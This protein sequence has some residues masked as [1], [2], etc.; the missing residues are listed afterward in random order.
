[1]QKLTSFA[2]LA[3]L[4]ASAT[5]Q[6]FESNYGTPLGTA[7]TLVGDIVLPI[8]SIGFAFPLAGTTYT[9]IHICDKGY[10][11]LSNAGVPAPGGADFSA[12]LAELANQGPRIAPLWSDL[13]VLASNNGQIYLNS[14]P[15]RCVVTW[16]NVRC[17]TGTCAAFNMQLQ[18]NVTGEILFFFGPGATNN[19]TT[20][21]TW[22]VGVCGVSPGATATTSVD[23]SAGGVTATNVL[24]EE[25]LTPNTF[26]MAARGLRLIPTNPGWVFTAPTGCAAA[27]PYGTGCLPGIDSIYENFTSGCDLANTT[28]TWLRTGGGYSVLNA[29]PGTFVTPS[30]SAINIAPL[31]LDGAQ[32]VTLSSP[33]PV[34]G[35]T[36]T[37]LVIT[38]KG[39]IQVASALPTTIDYTPT[40]AELL[41]DPLTTF[42][43]WH[44]FDQTDVGSGLILYEEVG[45]VAYATWNGVHSF[46]SVLPTTFQFQLDLASGSVT[47]VFGAIGGIASP[48]PGV[49]GFSVAGSSSDPGATDL[50][51]FAGVVSLVDGAAGLGLVANGAP[52][53]GNA[54]FS[55]TTTAVP[56]LIPLAIQFF[57]T[58]VINPG[59]NLTFLGMPGCF[60][61]TN[62]DL[63]SLSVPVVAGS[64]TLN[65]PVPNNPGLVGLV[66]STQ[67]LAFSAATPLGL[68]SSN[69]LQLNFGL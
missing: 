64:G 17:Y 60:G 33:M 56:G 63:V 26:D 24:G 35:G 15:T 67:S 10:V 11:W 45:G 57:G 55:M 9:D 7:A 27:L 50:S 12:T 54:A 38:T 65:L 40:V 29:V 2:T 62:G 46:S 1:M 14:S 5:A 36:T 37:S 61:Y 48:D 18:M 21:A 69:G 41:N 28:I 47:L 20:V 49:V 8:Q 51:A 66:V 32:V 59:L 52:Q 58:A 23:L 31:A 19:S 16:E 68:I 53:I 42:A 44:D 43:V 3:L 34:P 13:Q 22:Q 30:A 25:W 4:A 6:C 39:Q